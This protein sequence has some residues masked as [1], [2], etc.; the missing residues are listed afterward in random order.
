MD[1]Y[2]N[3]TIQVSPGSNHFFQINGTMRGGQRGHAYAPHLLSCYIV[4]GGRGEGGG[5]GGGRR[6]GQAAGGNQ[7]LTF[8]SKTFRSVSF[9]PG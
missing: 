9:N 1:T 8:G 5:G 3:I 6:L 2:Y 4:G 7:T